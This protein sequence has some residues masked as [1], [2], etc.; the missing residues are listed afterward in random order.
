M[1][2]FKPSTWGLVKVW[3][4]FENYR[5]WIHTIKTEERNKYSKYNKWN[6]NRNRFYTLYFTHSISEEEAQLPEQ[7]QRMRMLESMAPLH[8]Y[9]DE[10]LG[11]AGNLVPEFNQFF[12]E[13]GEP[14]FTY[15]VAY[16]Y[17]FDKF[18]LKWVAKFLLKLGVVITSIV[19]FFKAGGFQWLQGLI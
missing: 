19:L 12:D 14:T 3:R 1:A 15:L 6:L 10:E 13:D 11:F 9:L 5:D 18:S 7:I 4:D 16:R 2:L 17:A 8:R